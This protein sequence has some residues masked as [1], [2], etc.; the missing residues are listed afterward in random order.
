MRPW[1]WLC[2]LALGAGLTAAGGA[3]AAAGN[4]VA[5]SPHPAHFHMPVPRHHVLH[6]DFGF[7]PFAFGGPILA[8]GDY[9]NGTMPPII[10]L[11]NAPAQPTLVQRPIA[12]ERPSVETTP[13]GVVIV[14]GPGSRHLQP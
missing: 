9:L 14:R 3:P 1:T 11:S 4:L 5:R 12:D 6:H 8:P 2:L 13:E 10:V 7:G